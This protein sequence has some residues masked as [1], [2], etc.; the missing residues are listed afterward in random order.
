MRNE[1]GI[2]NNRY[3]DWRELSRILESLDETVPSFEEAEAKRRET[4]E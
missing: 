3:C 1:A 2:K 4:S